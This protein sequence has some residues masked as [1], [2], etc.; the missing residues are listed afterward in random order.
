MIDLETVKS[1][2]LNHEFFLE[3][4]PTVS[5]KDNRCVGCEAL[6]RWRRGRRVIPPL[7]FIPVIE[8]TLLSGT[9]TYWVI[10]N[11]AQELGPWLREH[12]DVHISMN[13][14]P[15][16]LGHAGLISAIANSNLLD[17]IDQLVVEVTESGLPAKRNGVPLARAPNSTRVALDDSALTAASLVTL[18]QSRIDIVKIDRPLIDQLLDPGCPADKLATLAEV[19]RSGKYVVVAEGVET[20]AQAERLKQLGVDLAQGWHFSRPLSAPD[21]GRYF[22][23]HR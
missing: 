17:V 8:S 22:A 21:F 19:L 1:G 14:P 6:I 15:G 18:S 20:Q 23:Q 13:I 10:E 16:M 4:L 2:L 9:V 5:L 3:Y 7:E 12:D 11:I